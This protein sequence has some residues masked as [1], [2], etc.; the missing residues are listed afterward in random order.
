MK[1]SLTQL[2]HLAGILSN[3]GHIFFASMVIP[4]LLSPIINIKLIIYGG[5]L[6]I[7]FWI[8]SLSLLKKVGE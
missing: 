3:I 1:F 8:C 7:F 6:A 2:N 4:F 5:W